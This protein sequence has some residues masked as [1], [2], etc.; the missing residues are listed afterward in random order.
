[1][2]FPNI[3]LSE[4]LYNAT[5]RFLFLFSNPLCPHLINI[6]F[7]RIYLKIFYARSL[8]PVRFYNGMGKKAFI[9][10]LC[11]DLCLFFEKHLVIYGVSIE[12][13]SW[14]VYCTFV[15]FFLCFLFFILS[16]KFGIPI[17]S[18]STIPILI[19]G[20]QGLCKKE[21][22]GRGEKSLLI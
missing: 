8:M 1:M 2:G 11:V 3:F 16:F 17:Y 12:I 9:V 6:L 20:I 21:E 14:E 4:N 19:L 7:L 5:R 13:N 18:D 22:L 10:E 15:S